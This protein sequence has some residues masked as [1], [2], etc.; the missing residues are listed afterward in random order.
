MRPQ[1][2]SDLSSSRVTIAVVREGWNFRRSEGRGAQ[3]ESVR[4]QGQVIQGLWRLFF[5]QTKELTIH[6]ANARVSFHSILT[7]PPLLSR[8]GEGG[9][10]RSTNKGQVYWP[11]AAN[12]PLLCPPTLLSGWNSE[13]GGTRGSNI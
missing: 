10:N 11:S 12:G 4:T 13:L 3:V 2:R 9:N 6:L 5:T 1:I 7:I 8:L